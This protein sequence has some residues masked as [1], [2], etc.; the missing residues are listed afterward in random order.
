MSEINPDGVGMLSLRYVDGVAQVVV[1]GGHGIPAE[2]TVVDGSGNAV[3]AYTA[4]PVTDSTTL[5]R[6][7]ATLIVTPA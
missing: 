6:N 3:A 4:G 5:L 2:L 7:Q 1:S